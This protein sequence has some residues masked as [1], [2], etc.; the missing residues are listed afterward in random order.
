MTYTISEDRSQL[1]LHVD[2]NERAALRWMREVESDDWGAV[3]REGELLD[4]LIANSELQWVDPFNTGDLTDAPL[5]GILGSDEE[6]TRVKQGPHGAVCV[7]HDEGGPWYVPIL[8]RWGYMPYAL[9]SFMD[10][11]ADDGRAEFVDRN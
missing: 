2:E 3:Y 5:L 4:T 1:T 10:D 8:E 11:L 9:R 7:G 6:R